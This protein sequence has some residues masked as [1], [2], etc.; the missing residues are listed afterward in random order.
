MFNYYCPFSVK[1]IDSCI[2]KIRFWHFPAQPEY[3]AVNESAVSLSA[4]SHYSCAWSSFFF[5]FSS[6]WRPVLL[7]PPTWTPRAG[8]SSKLRESCK[9]ET[10]GNQP[11]QGR[12]E[13][14]SLLTAPKRSACFRRCLPALLIPYCTA[15]PRHIM[16][17]GRLRQARQGKGRINLKSERVNNCNA[18]TMGRMCHRSNPEEK[19]TAVQSQI[20]SLLIGWNRPNFCRSFF[21]THRCREIHYS[22]PQYFAKECTTQQDV[23]Y[24]YLTPYRWWFPPRCRPWCFF[25]FFIPSSASFILLFC[26]KIHHQFSFPFLHLIPP[27]DWVFC[28][29]LK[30]SQPHFF[31]FTFFFFL[32]PSTRRIAYPD[33]PWLPDYLALP[34]PV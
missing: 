1:L 3:L 29:R 5:F 33:R 30:S 7:L 2:L 20:S 11:C 12:S 10:V 28:V 18:G 34:H 24:R 9:K 19:R 8:S 23:K 32:V 16:R 21:Y 22:T 6:I 13:Y 31:F 25:F 17:R 27:I 14:Y 15:R 4:F 26:C